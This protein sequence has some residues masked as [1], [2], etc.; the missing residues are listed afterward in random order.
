MIT[1]ETKQQSTLTV[2]AFIRERQFSPSLKGI[3]HKHTLTPEE[4][5]WQVGIVKFGANGKGKLCSILYFLSLE[6]MPAHAG[7]KFSVP[8]CP[9]PPLGGP[10]LPPG[11]SCPSPVR[12]FCL[13]PGFTAVSNPWGQYRQSHYLYWLLTV[14]RK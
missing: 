7:H 5:E 8:L 1:K 13:T 12:Q 6:S 11:D 3:F 14:N 9:E 10:P 4:E 2:W